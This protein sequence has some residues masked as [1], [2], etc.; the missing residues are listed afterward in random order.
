MPS[1]APRDA[2]AAGLAA[3]ASAL[4]AATLGAAAVPGAVAPLPALGAVVVDLAPVALVELAIEA[5]GR[6][7]KTALLVAVLAVG[8][9]LSATTGLLAQRSRTA[10]RLL[11]N[12]QL[13]AI[14]V[15][16]SRQEQAAFVPTVVVLVVAG[17]AGDL[18][19]GRLLP[20]RTEPQLA[21]GS[22]PIEPDAP[23]EAPDAR[24]AV[25]RRTVLRAAVL[26]GVAGALTA[27][28]QQ[29]NVAPSE[30]LL[31]A[32]RRPLPVVPAPLPPVPA[33]QPPGAS[34]L[35]TPVRDFYRVD[36]SLQPPQVEPSQWELTLRG[37]S[38][39]VRT[40]GYEQ[41]RSRPQ[42]EADVTI[43]C[44][45]NQVGGPLI[46][47]A[48]WQGLLLGD[49]LAEV[50]GAGRLLRSGRG[51]VQ[52][53]S[54]DGF[55]AS[56]PL[57][58]AVDGRPALLALGMNG[59]VLPVVHGFPARLVVPGLYGYSS[60][61]KWLASVEL[62]PDDGLP[63]YWVD[64]GWTPAVPVPPLARID[65]PRRGERVSGAPVTVAG[66]AWAPPLGVRGVQVRL[67]QGPWV[68]ARLGPDLGPAAWRQFVLR[69]EL[70]EG[71][72]EVTVRAVRADGQMQSARQAPVFPAGA[73][74][75]HTV[76]FSA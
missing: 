40:L 14:G 25:T 3:G 49:L 53:R 43:G 31:A 16:A 2:V 28:G 46:D 76:A 69:V 12:V 36:T 57:R 8:V 24:P 59:A 10:S 17:V 30:R 61:V 70:D 4:A 23:A 51:T 37:P 29:L 33:A 72:H 63:G 26:T 32:L 52:A 74:G 75:L 34:P 44:I 18:V 35:L 50:P 11:I 5:F 7:D 68:Q 27:V 55:L 56:F 1:P 58:Y 48:R 67:D 9:L 15:A 38:G 21:A 41:L 66:V 13:L 19:L 39:A 60:A 45:S 47:T 64:R 22:A 73:S 6:H 42:V 20:L 65:T 62:T 71:E 54:V